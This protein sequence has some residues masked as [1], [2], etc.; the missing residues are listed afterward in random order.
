MCIINISEKKSPPFTAESGGADKSASEPR[1]QVDASLSQDE[2]PATKNKELEEIEDIIRKLERL[3]KAQTLLEDALHLSD[4]EHDL[5]DISERSERSV[6]SRSVA[7]SSFRSGRKSVSKTSNQV[8][9][10]SD[11][12]GPQYDQ[13]LSEAINTG[14]ASIQEIIDKEQVQPEPNHVGRPPSPPSVS[15][16]SELKSKK[17]V[18]RSQSSRSQ[19]RKNRVSTKEFGVCFVLFFRF[20]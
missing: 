9:P 1:S 19:I 16:S 18:S 15:A 6:A 14:L 10:G 2:S 8:S 11:D 13:D 20:L 4:A 17:S 12:G 5:N 3:E 7:S